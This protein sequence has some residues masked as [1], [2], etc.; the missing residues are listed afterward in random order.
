MRLRR[1]VLAAFLVS[2]LSFGAVACGDGGEG[3]E[4]TGE[5]EDD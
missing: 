3:G 5:E 2:L 4:E 1:R